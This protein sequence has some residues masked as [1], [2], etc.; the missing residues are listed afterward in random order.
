MSI[1]AKTLNAINEI[2]IQLKLALERV[3]DLDPWNEEAAEIAEDLVDTRNKL[4]AYKHSLPG[5]KGTS[6]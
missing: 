3:Y 2:Q 6:G 5:Y 4:Q 1:D